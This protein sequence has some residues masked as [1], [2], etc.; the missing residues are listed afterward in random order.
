MY[1]LF[2]AELATNVGTPTF[3]IATDCKSG[4]LQLENNIPKNNIPVIK[5]DKSSLSLVMIPIFLN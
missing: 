2:I 1:L 5:T 4:E 3:D